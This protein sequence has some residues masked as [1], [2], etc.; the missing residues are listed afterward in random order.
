MTDVTRIL[1]QIEQGDSQAAEKLLRLVYNELRRFAAAK[2]AL[3]KPGAEY[4]LTPF[5]RT[6]YDHG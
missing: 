4:V 1:S 6:I 3:E 5:L 2:L